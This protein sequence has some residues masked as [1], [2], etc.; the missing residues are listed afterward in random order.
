MLLGKESKGK[1]K[2]GRVKAY[3]LWVFSN[4]RLPYRSDYAPEAMAAFLQSYCSCTLISTE[5]MGSGEVARMMVLS[6]LKW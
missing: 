2:K 6:R 1:A 3:I 4:Q 5:L